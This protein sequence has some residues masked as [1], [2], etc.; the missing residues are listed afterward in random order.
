[1]K[2]IALT[3]G[4]GAGKTAVLE[5]VRRQPWVRLFVLPEAAGI[6]YR[7]GFPRGP[8]DVERRA[9]QHAIFHVQRQLERIAEAR[10]GDGAALCDR[11]T[12]DGLAYW[13]GSE[14]E[15]WSEMAT[16]RDAELAR[17]AAV[18]HLRTPPADN[19]YT[20]S[21]NPLRTET[22]EEAAAID[23]RLLAAWD[24]HPCRTVIPWHEDFLH[25]VAGA[26][27]ALRAVL[28]AAPP[29][30]AAWSTRPGPAG[31]PSGETE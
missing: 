20:R 12:I 5:I 18:L 10:L 8:S 3:G 7:G 23:E 31:A 17:Y 4:P 30:D 28:P 19:G 13:P 9:A 22:A 25:K 14:A 1:M 2:L 21:G 24:G 26:V 27:A 15:Y 29:R 11:G 6:L 16:T